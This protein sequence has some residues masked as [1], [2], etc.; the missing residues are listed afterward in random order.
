MR[1]SFQV[2]ELNRLMEAGQRAKYTQ[3]DI[4][5]QVLLATKNAKLATSR[6]RIATNYIL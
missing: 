4:A 5:K 6:K 3:N 2:V 1:I